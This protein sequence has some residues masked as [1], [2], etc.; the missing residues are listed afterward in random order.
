M[1]EQLPP[2]AYPVASYA[3][4]RPA[5]PDM[6]RADATETAFMLW[7]CGLMIGTS[8]DA[9]DTKLRAGVDLSHRISQAAQRFGAEQ[10]AEL[11]RRERD[12]QAEL[13]QAATRAI[14]R[15]HPY[16]NGHTIEAMS[17]EM[18]ELLAQPSGAE[19]QAPDTAPSVD[20]G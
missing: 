14:E 3:E 6:V 8:R 9:D 4:N 7:I 20:A 10:R 13:S 15:P 16:A 5:T 12:R 17:P 11:E 18:A 1:T 19:G 2:Q